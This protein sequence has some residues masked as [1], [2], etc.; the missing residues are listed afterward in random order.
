MKHRQPLVERFM[1]RPLV[2][3]SAAFALLLVLIVGCKREQQAA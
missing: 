2:A 3:R 1:S